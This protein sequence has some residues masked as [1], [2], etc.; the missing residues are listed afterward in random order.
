MFKNITV[1]RLK[2]LGFF[3]LFLRKKLLSGSLEIVFFLLKELSPCF[4]R[5]L[6]V[7]ES[8]ARSSDTISLW[9]ALPLFVLSYEQEIKHVVL[10][11]V[12]AARTVASR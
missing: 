9:E 6:V 11:T 10:G 2:S 7:T 3:V 5:N 4:L 1:L 12:G 8:L